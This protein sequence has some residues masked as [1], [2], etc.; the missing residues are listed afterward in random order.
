MI[1]S[2]VL[3]LISSL[4][5]AGEGFETAS[6]Q[7]DAAEARESGK[8]ILLYISTTDCS[9]CRRLQRD[10]LDTMVSSGSYD[11][12]VLMRKLVWDSGLPVADFTG[13]TMLPADLIHKLNVD[14]TP[15]L[16][17]LNDQGKEVAER[18]V[19]YQ[20]ADFYWFYLDKNIEQARQSMVQ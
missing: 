4:L 11:E 13:Q 9:F 16:L 14:V 6:L 17:F 18:L 19:G 7:K 20:N 5:W 15:T 12:K 10:V 1:R 2:L 8:P 3:M